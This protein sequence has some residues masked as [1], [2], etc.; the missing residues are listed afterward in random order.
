[1]FPAVLV[2]TAKATALRTVRPPEERA[3]YRDEQ[4]AGVLRVLADDS[5][6]AMVVF[7]VD[8]GHTDSQWILPY[9]GPITGTARH[10]GSPG[11]TDLKSGAR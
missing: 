5:P 8:F 1:M 2:G 7:G 9:G 6:E 3:R 10:G 4:R 11:T